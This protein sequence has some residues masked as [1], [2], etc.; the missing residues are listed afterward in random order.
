MTTAYR[1]AHELM[2]EIAKGSLSP[3]ALMEE[4]LARIAAT[5]PKINAIVALRDEAALMDEARAMDA[6]PLKGPLHGLPF[7]VKD[8][9]ATKGITSSWGSPIFKDFVPSKDD[10]L[11]ARLRAA[12]AILIGKTNV[13]EFGL[14][15]HSFNPH[16]GTT[17]NPYDLE[18]SAGG[19]S[20]GA[21]AALAAG[22]VSLAD[23]SDMMGSLRN[24]AAWNNLY[25]LRPTH[26][27]VPAEPQGEM[28]MHPL[29][30][31]GPIARNPQDLALLL[32]VLAGPD[33]RVPYHWPKC[34]FQNLPHFSGAKIAWLG[35][36]GG[37]LAL[38]PSLITHLEASLAILSEAGATV[39]P[40][41]PPFPFEKIW[42]SW[43]RLRHFAIL[44]KL[45]GYASNP[46]QR[47]LLK[48]EAIWEI[49]GGQSLTPADILAA[50][51]DRSDW[52]RAAARSFE[53]FDFLALPATQTWP[54]AAEL[55]YPE[56]INGR[57]MDTYHHWMAVVTP[58]S[59]GGLPALTLPAGFGETGLP[60]GIQIIGPKGSDAQLLELANAYHSVNPWKDKRPTL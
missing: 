5:N 56:A 37:A 27:L 41:K 28:V 6:A 51:A 4:S 48:P 35:D 24:P 17:K 40:E 60:A 46:L 55:R 16:Y 49:E 26:G 18:K 32:N 21:G 7:A 52:L 34:D 11:A 54:F 8:L 13:P 12:G 57:A 33:P 53:S 15:S 42:A 50:S 3:S 20:G 30:T 14:G 9:V 38:E 23:G 36:W 31:D 39:A 45:G 22:F 44:G 25:S 29:S 10:L 43:C 58:A 59:L 2:D 47:D 1:P 19:S